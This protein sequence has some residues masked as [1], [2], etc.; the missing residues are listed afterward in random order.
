MQNIML[1]AGIVCAVAGLLLSAWDFIDN[2]R[3]RK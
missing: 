3:K 1:G 2:R